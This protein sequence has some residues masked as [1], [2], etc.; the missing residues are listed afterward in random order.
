MSNQLTQ[1]YN[2]YLGLYKNPSF[3]G[4]GTLFNQAFTSIT[5]AYSDNDRAIFLICSMTGFNYTNESGT[6]P[7]PATGTQVDYFL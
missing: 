1:D 7:T 3:V 5:A 6:I 4:N 2:S